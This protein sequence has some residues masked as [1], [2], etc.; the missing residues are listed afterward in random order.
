MSEPRAVLPCLKEPEWPGS[1]DVVC[2]RLRLEV[3]SR[4]L[5]WVAF[6]Y[7]Q[8]HTFE[9]LPRARL[10]ELGKG[11]HDIER[12]ALRNLRL[13]KATWQSSDI[14]LGLFKKLRM[15]VC[16]DEY[17]AA[18]RIL[19]VGFMKEAHGKLRAEVLAVGIPRRG[20]LLAISGQEPPER[21]TGFAG[22]VSAQY[23]REESPPI[24]PAVFAVIDGKL[25]GMLQGGEESDAADEDDEGDE[26]ESG[27]YIQGIVT[28]NQ[29][30]QEEVSIC[31]GGE[32]TEQLGHAIQ[33]AFEQTLS[34]HVPRREFGGRIQVVLLQGMVPEPV[35]R[36]LRSLEAHLQGVLAEAKIET[37][38]GRPVRVSFVE[39]GD[40]GL[41]PL[42]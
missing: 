7:D 15:L 26:D 10:V 1:A 34:K 24:T 3:E 19:D 32:D 21:L 2:H 31:V 13:R 5:P 41:T 16:G 8:P 22:M 14:K 42:R 28:E 36:H 18:E 30:G 29:E 12:E 27:V 38:S 17:F 40:Q 35:K 25:A 9:F 23:H 11:E 6:G 33:A 20:F 39:Q 4:Y 37:V